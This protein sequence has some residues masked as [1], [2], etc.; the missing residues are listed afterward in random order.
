MKTELIEP[1]MWYQWRLTYSGRVEIAVSAIGYERPEKNSAG[2]AWGIYP[3]FFN[4]QE[5]S[6]LRFL[7]K[8]LQDE[9]DPYEI[10]PAVFMTRWGDI[11][12][13]KL[14]EQE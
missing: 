2:T 1:V 7:I 3:K 5:L 10:N 13:F 9:F 8:E 4:N 12:Y 11:I 14:G 6:M